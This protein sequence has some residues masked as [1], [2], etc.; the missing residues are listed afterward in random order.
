MRTCH[1]SIRKFLG[2]RELDWT[3]PNKALFRLSGRGDSTRSFDDADFYRCV[4]TNTINVEVV[5]G[6]I[7]DAC[8]DLES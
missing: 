2:I 7:I 6:D 4:P 1:L 5:L 8:S 3:V